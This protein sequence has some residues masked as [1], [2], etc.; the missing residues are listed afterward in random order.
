MEA[1]YAQ[2]LPSDADLKVRHYVGDPPSAEGAGQRVLMPKAVALVIV[3]WPEGWFL[4]R[5]GPRASFAGDTW[6]QTLDH[7]YEQAEYECGT[8]IEWMQVPD[9]A[10]DPIE[11]V[12]KSVL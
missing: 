5:Y 1:Y 4:Y 8:G 6:H 7:A 10:G 3:S 11:F 12:R 2:L 9:D